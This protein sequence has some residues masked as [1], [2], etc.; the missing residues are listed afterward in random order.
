MCIDDKLGLPYHF[1][2]L[3]TFSTDNQYLKWNS[4][5]LNYLT[6]VNI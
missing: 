1:L 6:T 4:R 2:I 5:L 3:T